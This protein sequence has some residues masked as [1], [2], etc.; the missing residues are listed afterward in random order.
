MPDSTSVLLRFGSADCSEGHLAR[1]RDGLSAVVQTGPHLWV[2]CDEGAALD[3]LTV[4]PDGTFG[5]HRS[6]P[7]ADYLDLPGKDGQEADLEGLASDPPYLWIVGSHSRRRGKPDGSG[8][9]ADDVAKLAEVEREDRRYL[10]ARVPLETDAV[11]G[12]LVPRPKTTYAKGEAT[13]A[14]LRG[15]GND[16]ALMDALRKDPH[17]RRSLKIP[18]KDNGFDVEGIAAAGGRLFLGLRGPV[19]RGWAVVLEIEPAD[20]DP[21]FLRL[22]RIGPEK[23]RYRKHF[24]ELEGMGIRGLSKDGDDLLV[25][26]GATMDVAAPA[27]LFRWRGGLRQEGESVVPLGDELV[28]LLELPHDTGPYPGSDHPEGAA[29]LRAE[30]LAP[31]VLVVSESAADRRKQDGGVVADLFALP[32]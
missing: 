17:L 4:Q 13:A 20:D 1:L 23:R 16:S 12:E 32:G 28:K 24:L 22:R 25:L 21:G 15:E 5:E 2:L 30:G 8:D 6:F 3:R 26:A 18:G 31:S 19:L 9:M 7:L 10:L 14:R 27:A 29:P 11:T